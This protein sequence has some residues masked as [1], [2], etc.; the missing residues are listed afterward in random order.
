MPLGGSYAY[1]GLGQ[2][3]QLEDEPELGD[4]WIAGGNGC[5]RQHPGRGAQVVACRSWAGH[6]PVGKARG[7]IVGGGSSP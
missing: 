4:Q 2:H 6:A 7:A 1:D 3:C 5:G